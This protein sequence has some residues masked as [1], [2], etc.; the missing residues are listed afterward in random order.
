[1]AG[2]STWP[3]GTEQRSPKINAEAEKPPEAQEFTAS[4]SNK[5]ELHLRPYPSRPRPSCNLKA[6]QSQCL[7]ILSIQ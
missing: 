6:T 2:I 7:L 5:A 4:L 3:L 1:M